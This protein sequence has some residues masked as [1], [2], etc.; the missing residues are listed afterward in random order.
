MARNFNELRAKM[1][2][3]QR[4]A[5][6][7]KAREMMAEMLLSEIRRE[8]GMTQED[9]AASLGITQ[10]ALSRMESQSDIQ[11]STLYRIIKALGGEMEILVRMPK[12]QVRLTQFTNPAA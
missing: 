11:I 8:T 9:L 7:Q 12:G 1:T 10:P 4:D 6:K 3:R 5:V 2:A